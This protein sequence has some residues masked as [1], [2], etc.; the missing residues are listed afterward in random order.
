MLSDTLMMWLAISAF[1]MLGTG[2]TIWV[3][4]RRATR[5]SLNIT[6][7]VVKHRGTDA[8]EL[9]VLNQRPGE[10][11]IRAIYIMFASGGGM[12]LPPPLPDSAPLPLDL[13]RTEAA[14]LR[15]SFEETTRQLTHHRSEVLRGVACLV[16]PDDLVQRP[17]PQSVVQVL[18]A[19][20]EAAAPV[21]LLECP[22]CASITAFP[23]R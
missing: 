6:P 3:V 13:P 11:R 23:G 22:G 7:A 1:V 19:A 12:A 16:D 18:V 21:H 9:K 8:L 2:T 4:G 10:A 15:Y 5:A 20:A 14:Y 17:L